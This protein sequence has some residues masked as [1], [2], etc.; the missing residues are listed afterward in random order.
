M[1]NVQ[2][3]AVLV[4]C[5]RTHIDIPVMCY[6]INVFF[7]LFVTSASDVHSAA[8][9]VLVAVYILFIFLFL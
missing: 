9:L 5:V 7:L 8:L 2:C 6:T 4:F 3:S 1:N